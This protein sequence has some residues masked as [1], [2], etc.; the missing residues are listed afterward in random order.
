MCTRLKGYLIVA[1]LC[2][3]ACASS[4]QPSPGASAARELVRPPPTL[5]AGKGWEPTLE[6]GQWAWLSEGDPGPIDGSLG[7]EPGGRGILVMDLPEGAHEAD[8]RWM[9]VGYASPGGATWSL[10]TQTA[11]GE[12]AGDPVW[13]ADVDVTPDMAGKVGEFP[14][15][16]KETRLEFG[17]AAHV[18][19]RFYLVFTERSPHPTVA[20]I[21]TSGESN[22]RYMQPGATTSQPAPAKAMVRLAI[23]NI[24]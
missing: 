14:N 19:G 17:S 24:R 7:A 1:T 16:L 10:Y 13:S 3:A 2:L 9:L 12:P 11:G 6:S 23:G 20:S 4:P 18:T 5:V 15:Y 8:L 22:V 21:R